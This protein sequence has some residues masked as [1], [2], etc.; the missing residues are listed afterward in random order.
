M[1]LSTCICRGMGDNHHKD[2]PKH[3]S[4]SYTPEVTVPRRVTCPTC[5][6]LG[7]VIEDTTARFPDVQS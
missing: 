5:K 6:G 1:K 2:C 7:T 4:Y 3:K